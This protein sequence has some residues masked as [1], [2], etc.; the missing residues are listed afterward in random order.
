MNQWVDGLYHFILG[1]NFNL[2]SIKMPSY[3]ISHVVYLE[4]PLDLFVLDSFGLDIFDF[5]LY[6][7]LLFEHFF[8]ICA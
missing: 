2:G 8:H 7:S 3:Q 4:P 1:T 5:I 6:I